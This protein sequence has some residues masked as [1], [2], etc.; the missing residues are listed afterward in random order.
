[1]NREG[2]LRQ[3]HRRI[4]AITLTAALGILVNM[5]PPADWAAMAAELKFLPWGGPLW[6]LVRAAAVLAGNAF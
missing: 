6:W 1:M 2:A 3:G 5:L 4:V